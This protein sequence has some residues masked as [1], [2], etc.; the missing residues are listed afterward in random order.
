MSGAGL[1]ELA[2][3]HLVEFQARDHRLHFVG[4]ASLRPFRGSCYTRLVLISDQRAAVNGKKT[5]P[6]MLT[7]R[8]LLGLLGPSVTATRTSENDRVSQIDRNWSCGCNGSITVHDG[9]TAAWRPCERHRNIFLASEPVDESGSALGTLRA[10]LS[11]RRFQLWGIPTLGLSAAVFAKAI[12]DAN[13]L[14]RRAQ[15]AEDAS[16]VDPLTGL[17]NR[18]G[19]DRRIE[20]ESK[21]LKRDTKPIVAVYMLDVDGLKTTN[22]ERG[23]A[24]GDVVL[25]NVSKVIGEVTREHDVSAR[26]GGD[27][28]A[29]LTVQS[30][31]AEADLVRARLERGFHSASLSVS[32]G[33][34]FANSVDTI[35]DAMDRADIMMYE[36]KKSHQSQV[37]RNR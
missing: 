28:F 15:E 18:R 22:D 5:K 6:I 27:E 34:A 32:I 9:D 7:E 16:L 23:H 19:W 14:L 1:L 3:V 33:F 25:R 30:Q 24:A 10:V 20:E 11:N 37:A 12:Y 13:A 36:V 35:N 17:Y 8:L 26:L 4:N 29:I 21:R 31:A 2:Y